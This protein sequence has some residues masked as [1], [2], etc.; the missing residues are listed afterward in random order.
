M[1][2]Y[3]RDGES[4]QSLV[5]EASAAGYQLAVVRADVSSAKGREQIIEA[6]AAKFSDLSGI[7]FAAATGVHRPFEQLSERF[8][9]FTYSLNVKAFLA[10]TQLLLPK[11][12]S[13][14]SIVALSS[15]G[16]ERA[17]IHYGLVGSS[18]AALESLCRHMAVELAP[19]GVRVN[20][21]SPG[22]V[23]TDVWK[24]LPDAERRLADAAAS[25]PRGRLTTVEEVAS[26][27]QFLLSAASSGLSGHTLVVDGG[28]RIA[29]SC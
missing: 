23:A 6:V 11:L 8:F 26:S 24:V 25:T 14:A 4:A 21:L 19:R 18:K 29:G 3:V 13:A 10:I 2:N 28:A 1:V 20:I 17:M 5:A 7:V 16:A 27:A 22:A 12:A 15:E 9:D